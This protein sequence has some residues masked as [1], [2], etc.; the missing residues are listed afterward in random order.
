MAISLKKRES[1][2][3]KIQCDP[4]S[5]LPLLS[6]VDGLFDLVLAYLALPYSVVEFGCG[7]KT[8]LIL[9]Y[10]A[11]LGIPFHALSRGLIMERDLS[12][13]ALAET[14]PSN[15]PHAL[16]AKNPLAEIKQF[17]DPIIS[18]LLHD[19][20]P[21]VRI[22]NEK[23]HAGPYSLSQSPEVQFVIAR[24]HVFAV[25]T[26]WDADRGCVTR[27][28]IDPAMQL[29]RALR[30]D[31]LRELFRAPEALIFE[32]PLIERFHLDASLLTDS[33][34]QE[35]DHF[36]GPDRTLDQ[37]SHED[38]AALV[39][40]LTGAGQGT[41]GDP[42]TW[43]YANNIQSDKL[44]K[45][46]DDPESFR[47]HDAAQSHITNRPPKLRQLID[48]LLHER[49]QLGPQLPAL[50]AA[51]ESYAKDTN[52]RQTLAEDAAW[53]M[54][55]LDILA[56]VAAT[57]RYAESLAYLAS[58]IA[59]RRSLTGCLDEP[60]CTWNMRGVGVR[61][62]RR[63]DHAADVSRA[64]HEAAPHHAD[65]PIDAR[66]LSPG[67]I[68]A[69]IETIRQM[70]AAGLRVTI[71]RV[72]NLHG[73]LYGPV[74]T[75]DSAIPPHRIAH[76]SHIDTVLDAGKF[77]G[78][79]GVL[80]GVET[81]HV[82]RDL[83]RYYD[84]PIPGNGHAALQV[85]SYVGEEMTFTGE[86]VSMPGSAAVTGRAAPE[87][88]H[89]MTNAD[90][91][92]WGDRLVDMLRH[93]REAKASGLIDF[94]NDL[95]SANDDPDA[96]LDACADPTDF[97]TPHTFERHIEQG[98]ILDRAD[99][100]LVLVG[101]I[102]GIRQEDFHFSGDRAEEAGA[103]LIGELRKIAGELESDDA[104]LRATVGVFESHPDDDDAICR[105]DLSFAVG[106]RLG[107]ELNHAGSTPN[108]DRADPGVAVS[109]LI[110]AFREKLNDH[111]STQLDR[112]LIGNLY[113]EPGTN[114]NVIPGAAGVAL[115]LPAD[116]SFAPEFLAELRHHLESTITQTLS[117]SVH[118]G[119]EGITLQQLDDLSF[120]RIS[121]RIRLSLDLR[122]AR[123]SSCQA[124]LDRLDSICDDLC[125]RYHV[126]LHREPQQYLTPQHLEES[127][128]VL[129]LERSFGGSHTPRET[130]LLNDII[131]AC[132][133]QID[134][135]QMALDHA[136]D[137]P[138]FNL[139][140]LVDEH[141]P[142]TWKY[143]LAR[144]T[145]GALHDTCNT[146]ARSAVETTAPTT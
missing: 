56:D 34:R 29:T 131:R 101:T 107:G 65:D 52:L 100:P 35:I 137:E 63:L 128:Q 77:D 17:S 5:G 48:A 72:G 90:G 78:R 110:D 136:L 80:S 20:C 113:L 134:V 3:L 85:S 126:R 60:S 95:D 121:R 64:P 119:G 129:I 138:D 62:R 123:E 14:D 98:P 53:S 117:R 86:G 54:A 58:Q 41:I 59:D 70:N 76:A 12:S 36:L 104:P 50:L 55:Q 71:D 112:A 108:A 105:E 75:D 31:E 28:A 82:F 23:L 8:S 91:E 46:P 73:L 38:H 39:R 125:R 1:L 19:A 27:R 42:L 68:A 93:F 44:I 127:G 143:R 10:L 67:F 109:R 139:F 96:L 47:Q 97:F 51:I 83:Q 33:Q 99:V 26:L 132:I 79:L 49:E 140:H 92:C 61:L 106:C 89:R 24:S 103:A 87:K 7:K 133:L 111:D 43:T 25:I 115:G 40:Q 135:S 18:R 102:M 16:I 21:S 74:S 4:S 6:E 145:S 22:E 116:T 15:R 142:Q 122:F 32:A 118:D 146:A 130:E 84:L 66:A 57:L 11:R 30:L 120:V 144:F 9:H 94:T 2:P 45:S 69:S 37:L 81:A 124:Y 141:I 13:A 114:R 88:I